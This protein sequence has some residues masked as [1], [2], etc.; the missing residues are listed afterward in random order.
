LL[1]TDGLL[2]PREELHMTKKRIAIMI[3]ILLLIVAGLSFKKFYKDHN[4]SL[5]HEFYNRS[6]L[7][8]INVFIRVNSLPVWEDLEKVM[9]FKGEVD[10]YYYE[11]K[12][13][14]TTKETVE[15]ELEM[16]KLFDTSYEMF[17]LMERFH[18]K[19]PEV[20]SF[21]YLEKLKEVQDHYFLFAALIEL[22]KIP[23]TN[24]TLEQSDHITNDFLQN[25]Y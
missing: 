23:I 18:N 2:Y 19:D 7:I 16:K 25:N 11:F 17:D 6:L 10:Q 9:T 14:K 1:I 5:T 12:Q 4:Q 20:K 15:G 13:L 22:K 3:L 8:S 21:A 24:E